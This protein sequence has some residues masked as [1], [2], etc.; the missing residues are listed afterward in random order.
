LP[1]I[2]IPQAVT[3]IGYNVFYNCTSLAKVTIADS[4]STLTLGSNGS[5]PIFASCPLDYVYI[6]RDISYKTSSSSGYS[7]FYRNTSLRAVKITD[8]E[9]E[10]SE[11]EFYGC[12]NLQQVEIGDGVTTIG[13]WAFSGCSSLKYFAFGSQVTNIGQEA[14]SDCTAVTEITSLATTPPACGS[15]ALDD[16]NKWECKLFVPKGCQT[17]Y[18]NAEQWKDFFF[19]EEGGGTLLQAIVGDA[20]GDGKVNAADI[21]EMVN[22]KN[23]KASAIFNLQNADMD[24]NDEINQAD[25][26]AVVNIIMSQ[27]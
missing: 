14:F 24:G 7:P 13:N 12:T 26:D 11:N 3:T 5:K 18:G 1:S 4:E 6:G 25:I 22:A 15:Q 10:I 16:I 27:E 9:T 23:G 19:M 17:A 21:V 20:N 2:T 8:K